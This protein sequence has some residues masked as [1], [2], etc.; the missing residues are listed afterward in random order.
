MNRPTCLYVSPPKLT[1]HIPSDWVVNA[2]TAIVINEGLDTPKHEPLRFEDR[3]G[4]GNRRAR[5]L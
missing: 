1:V 4:F 2:I 3:S 5:Y